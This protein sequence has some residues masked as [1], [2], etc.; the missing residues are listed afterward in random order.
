MLTEKM[1]IDPNARVGGYPALLIRKLVRGLNNHLNWDWETVQRLLAAEP[2]EATELV[3]T[4][5]AAGRA[6]AN[7]DKGPKTWTTTQLAQSFGSATAAKPIT[8]QTAS[9]SL[10][11]LLERVDRVNSDEHFLARVTRLILFGRYLR[12]EVDR[13]SDV[14]VAVE[15]RP[16]EADRGRARELNHQRIAEMERNGHR[17]SRSLDRESW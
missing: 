13:L 4:L 11:Q 9:A 5:E 17:F 15:L 16:K 8:R 2:S 7:R 1:R 3:K 10:N 12:P 14:D 6:K